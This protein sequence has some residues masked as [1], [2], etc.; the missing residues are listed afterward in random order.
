MFRWHCNADR[1]STYNEGLRR[2]LRCPLDKLCP[3]SS[4]EAPGRASGAG[5]REPSAQP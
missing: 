3:Q 4:A 1:F 5:V 2:S